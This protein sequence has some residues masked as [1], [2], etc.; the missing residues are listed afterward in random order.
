MITEEYLRPEDKVKKRIMVFIEESW[1][2]IYKN[3]NNSIDAVW[4]F[5]KDTVISVFRKY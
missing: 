3:L 1:P 4:Q 2:S 5:I